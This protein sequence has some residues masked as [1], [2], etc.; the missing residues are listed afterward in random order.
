VLYAAGQ[1]LQ[2]L[3]RG[4]P[5]K[6][7]ASLDNLLYVL[8]DG[9]SSEQLEVYHKDS[10]QLQRKLTVSG[11]GSA[12][13]IVACGHYYCAYISDGTNYVVH[14]LALPS[15]AAKVWPVYKYKPSCLSVTHLHSVLVTSS[16]ARLIKEYTTDGELLR[17]VKLRSNIP[18]HAVLSSSGQ[19]TVC[20]G[21]QFDHSFTHLVCE[22]GFDGKAVKSFGGFG[23]SGRQNMYAPAHLAVDR[24][25]LNIFIA[26]LGNDRVL[27]LSPSLTFLREVV[28]TKQLRGWPARLCLD[29]DKNRLYVAVNDLEGGQVAAV[30]I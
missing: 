13:D 5:I 21:E 25:D 26:D 22:V 8:R 12:A 1:V 14:R 3:P 19:F 10:F 9:L 17:E 2:T 30:S 18:C 27:L 6:G 23:G 24:R 16:N 11:L 4:K 15:F 28:S 29:V 7:V 20:H